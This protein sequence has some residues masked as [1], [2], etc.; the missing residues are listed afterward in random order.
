MEMVHS[1]AFYALFKKPNC[2]T[3]GTEQQQKTSCLY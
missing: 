2:E 1:G 3:R